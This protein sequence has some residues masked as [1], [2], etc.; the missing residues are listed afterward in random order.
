MTKEMLHESNPA[1]SCSM[2]ISSPGSPGRLASSAFSIHLRRI[3]SS[4]RF[5]LCG[6]MRPSFCRLAKDTRGGQVDELK[7]LQLIPQYQLTVTLL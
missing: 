6:Q 7:S 4:W 3:A 5:F 1:A 2:T